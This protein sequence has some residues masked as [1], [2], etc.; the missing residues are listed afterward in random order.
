MKD[1]IDLY[2]YVGNN[3]WNNVDPTGLKG[4]KKIL[5]IV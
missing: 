5:I 4:C 2:A 1:D 3:P